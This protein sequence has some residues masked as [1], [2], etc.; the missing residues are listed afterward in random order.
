MAWMS[1]QLERP[2][3]AGDEVITPAVTFPTTLAPLVHGGVIP[4]F[5][6]CEIDTCN[7]NPA[8]PVESNPRRARGSDLAADA[9]DHGSPH[10]RQSLRP[11]RHHR[12]RPPPRPAPDR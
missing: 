9:C 5:V 2:L 3:A 12:H 8:A 4:V 7:V 10:A 6:D 11:R 1:R